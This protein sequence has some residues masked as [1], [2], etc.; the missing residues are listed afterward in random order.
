M[1][2]S[3][4]F[5]YII[6]KTSDN[7][8]QK[9]LNFHL[10]YSGYNFSSCSLDTIR[11]SSLFQLHSIIIPRFYFIAGKPFLYIRSSQTFR[12]L[13]KTCHHF[14]NL[15]PSITNNRLRTKFRPSVMLD[16]VET[17][18]FMRRLSETKFSSQRG[19]VLYNAFGH[20]FNIHAAITAF[21]RVG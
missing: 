7:T 2:S 13:P 12:P 18:R 16:Y 19:S 15:N 6:F 14:G 4:Y 5:V 17:F 21:P 9:T 8:S 11:D 3:T 1:F 20:H 10:T